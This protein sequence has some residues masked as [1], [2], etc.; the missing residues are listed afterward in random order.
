M[1]DSSKRFGPPSSFSSQN[2]PSRK[3]IFFN[4]NN[5]NDITGIRHAD[6]YYTNNLKRGISRAGRRRD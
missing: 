1:L 6:L 5:N 2:Y 4:K 3:D